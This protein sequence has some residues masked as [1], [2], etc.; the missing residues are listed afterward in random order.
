M[1]K[2]KFTS[3]FKVKTKLKV[4]QHPT[5]CYCRQSTVSALLECA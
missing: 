4:I 1:S 3:I 2:Y 5:V